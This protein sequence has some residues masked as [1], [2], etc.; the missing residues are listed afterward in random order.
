M[1]STYAISVGCIGD[2]NG[3]I[4][5]TILSVSLFFNDALSRPGPKGKETVPTT[6]SYATHGRA[7]GWCLSEEDRTTATVGVLTRAAAQ[8]PRTRYKKKKKKK[9]E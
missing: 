4:I 7:G 3:K 1:L 8:Q 5:K 2:G 6:C 9:R